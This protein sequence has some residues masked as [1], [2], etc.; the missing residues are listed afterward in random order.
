MT[1]A[2]VC[3]CFDLSARGGAKIKTIPLTTR[4]P[5]SNTGGRCGAHAAQ[6]ELEGRRKT[7]PT[8]NVSLKMCS[9]VLYS[10]SGVWYEL[11]L[12]LCCT[13]SEGLRLFIGG[14]FDIERIE[15]ESQEGK[16]KRRGRG[17]ETETERQREDDK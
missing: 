2:L 9:L 11:L 4:L 13:I 15:T 3:S 6:A 14:A 10:A 5:T 1:T 7:L 16:E 17:S 8:T 12:D